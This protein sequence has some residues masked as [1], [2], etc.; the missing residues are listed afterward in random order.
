[1]KVLIIILAVS[2]FIIAL[3]AGLEALN[4]ISLLVS[5]AEGQAGEQVVISVKIENAAGT[6]GGQFLLLFDPDFIQPLTLETG[7]MIKEANNNLHMSNLEYQYGELIFMWVTPEADTDDSGII[8]E[9]TFNLIKD[10]VAVLTLDEVVLVPDGLHLTSLEHG[11]VIV[12]DL[13]VGRHE[14]EISEQDEALEVYSK[15]DEGKEIDEQ[16]VGSV[17]NAK[18]DT[19]L[20]TGAARASTL[21]YAVLFLVIA[22]VLGFSIY[23]KKTK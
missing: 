11:K 23:L 1:M 16:A 6:E 20:S 4:G 19:A 8:C 7:E 18:E 2:I 21:I 22:L 3:P 10:G 5:S 13:E 15:N 12:G 17:V 9:I 14:D